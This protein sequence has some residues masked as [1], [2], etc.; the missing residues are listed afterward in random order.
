[1]TTVCVLGAT[2]LVGRE[3]LRCLE[4]RGFPLTRLVPLAR[5]GD[6]GRRLRFRGEEHVVERARPAALAAADLVL[7]SAGRDASRKLLPLACAGGSTCVDNSSAFRMDPEVP[8]VVPEVNG[9]CLDARPTLVANPN[10]STI[11]LVS[12]LEPLRAAF[13][14]SSVQVATYQSASGAGG[15]ALDA[16]YGTPETL[17]VVPAVGPLDDDDRAEEEVKLERETRK[18]LGLE[19][20]VDALCVRVPTRVGHGEAVWVRTEE[21]MDLALACEVLEGAPGIRLD[22]RRGFATPRR[23]REPTWCVSAASAVPES[24]ACASGWRP[25][26]S[27]RER[28]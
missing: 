21:R 9:E 12:V 22:G 25:T 28:R 17:D 8:L 14:L 2:G 20:P 24:T 4:E 10:C 19:L 15:A 11:Q 18:I 5:E 27:A 3:M 7:A 23:S 13:G 16:L 1:M 26:T 6:G